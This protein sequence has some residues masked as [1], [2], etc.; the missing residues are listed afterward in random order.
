MLQWLE[1]LG[2]QLL[3]IFH[4]TW[5]TCEAEDDEIWH[6]QKV[7]TTIHIFLYFR[8]DPHVYLYDRDASRT[9][10]HQADNVVGEL[11]MM[12]ENLIYTSEG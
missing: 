11:L 7:Y 12:K 2:S 9:T 8:I 4:E 3:S 6:K 10:S 1:R 5:L